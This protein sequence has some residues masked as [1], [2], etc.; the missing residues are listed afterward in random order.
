MFINIILLLTVI[1]YSM[2]VSQSFMYILALRNLSLDLDVAAYTQMRKIIDANMRS[3]YSI[4]VYGSLILNLL[5][6][7][8]L[9]GRHSG[10]LFIASTI[11][12]TALLID[13]LLMVKGN[14]PLN[15]VINEW[16]SEK[17]PGNWKDVRLKWLNIYQQRQVVNIIGFIALV[18]GIVFR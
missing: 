9:L 2:I 3:K 11:S 6:V 12:M 17:I 16:T 7:V 13:T 4:V 18:A 5:L 14:M 1:F 8:L 10:T 15:A